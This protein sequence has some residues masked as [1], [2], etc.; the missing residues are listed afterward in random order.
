MGESSPDQLAATAKAEESAVKSFDASSTKTSTENE[1]HSAAQK[2]MAQAKDVKAL[3]Q[4]ESQHNSKF[5]QHVTESLKQAEEAMKKVLAAKSAMSKGSSDTSH[6]PALDKSEWRCSSDNKA[7]AVIMSG[8][9]PC[10]ASASFQAD[11]GLGVFNT[12]GGSFSVSQPEDSLKLSTSCRVELQSA[13]AEKYAQVLMGLSQQVN[14]CD[15]LTDG[16]EQEVEAMKALN[17][18]NAKVAA[19]QK[20]EEAHNE[21]TDPELKAAAAMYRRAR[22]ELLSAQQDLESRKLMAKKTSAEQESLESKSETDNADVERLGK[23]AQELVDSAK[24]EVQASQTKVARMTTDVA[25]LRASYLR[26]TIDLN[27][28]G[29][30]EVDSRS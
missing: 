10:A 11:G 27:V 14:K 9:N 3:A 17:E 12:L 16:T 8:S 29:R 22:Q 2:L 6:T 21:A 20:T 18:Q 15:L 1:S 4:Q 5:G 26:A 7:T 28:K 30:T 13:S 24:A 25:K 23:E 19:A